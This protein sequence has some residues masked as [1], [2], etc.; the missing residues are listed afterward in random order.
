MNLTDLAIDLRDID[1][2]KIRFATA[3]VVGTFDSPAGNA[4]QLD[5]AGC[6][7]LFAAVRED[8]AE[9]W[10]NEHPQPDVA[11]IS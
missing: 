6:E 5:E 9:K 11:S 3:P 1:Q 7:Q 10:L 4:V 2:E 8:R